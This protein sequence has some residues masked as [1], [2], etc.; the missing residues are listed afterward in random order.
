MSAGEGSSHFPVSQSP[1]RKGSERGPLVLRLALP[2]GNAAYLLTCSAARRR[3]AL[4]ELLASRRTASAKASM[5]STKASA[6]VL[7]RFQRSGALT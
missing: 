5:L 4:P 7:R 6:P 3:Y 2:K 1:W